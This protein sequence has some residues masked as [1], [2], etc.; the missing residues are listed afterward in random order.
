MKRTVALPGLVQTNVVLAEVAKVINDMSDGKF[1]D[2]E[3][4]AKV[5]HPD[6]KDR[7]LYFRKVG[8]RWFLENRQEDLPPPKKEP[9]KG[10][11]M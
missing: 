11:G 7:A 5:T 1:E 3:T 8:D 6:V 10:P 4:G 2:T 9:E